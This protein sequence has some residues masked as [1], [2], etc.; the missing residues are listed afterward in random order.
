A[1][2]AME[3]TAPNVANVI[4]RCCMRHLPSSGPNILSNGRAIPSLPPRKAREEEASS[5]NRAKCHVVSN[6]V[7]VTD[8]VRCGGGVTSVVLRSCIAGQARQAQEWRRFG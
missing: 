1:R 2:A 3:T 5:F 4:I 8:R 6:N 7:P